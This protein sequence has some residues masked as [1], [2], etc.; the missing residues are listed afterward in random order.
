[1]SALTTYDDVN[2][3]VYEPEDVEMDLVPDEGEVVYEE[4]V[5]QGTD[6][7]YVAEEG[8]AA[9]PYGEVVE[10]VVEDAVEEI[11]DEAVEG[12]AVVDSYQ[13]EGVAEEY[14]EEAAAEEPA[15]QNEADFLSRCRQELVGAEQEEEVA[16]VEVPAEMEYDEEP[17]EFSVGAPAAAEDV[18]M[19]ASTGADTEVAEAVPCENG[20][21]FLCNNTT[22]ISCAKFQMF[23]SPDF[24]INQMQRVIKQNGSTALFL[25]N[26]QRMTLMGPFMATGMPRLHINRNAFGGKFNAQVQVRPLDGII[27]ARKLEGRVRSG[28]KTAAEVEELR[29]LLLAGEPLAEAEQQVWAKDGDASTSNG[30]GAAKGGLLVPRANGS[31]ATAMPGGAL[32]RPAPPA[33]PAPSLTAAEPTAGDAKR[34]NLGQ[35]VVKPTP[36]LA[37][38]QAAA[39][40][41][42]AAAA[43]VAAAAKAQAA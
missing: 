33:P 36:T 2:A 20:Y 3:D 34:Q 16:V 29:A 23:G 13:E 18:S 12:E 32:K 4:E 5:A 21:V 30:N 38:Q 28:P 43:R 15:S 19:T 31:V 26:T 22:L 8:V 7:Y 9:D 42:A 24:E 40:A 10:E 17:E 41:K 39:A 11:V 14:V 25:V 37:Q 1:M 35:G 27:F 6:D